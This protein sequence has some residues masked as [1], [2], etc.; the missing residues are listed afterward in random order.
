[1]QTVF[2]QITSHSIAE[3]I[4][5]VRTNTDKCQDNPRLVLKQIAKLLE[6]EFLGTYGLQALLGQEAASQGTSSSNHAEE[7]T[8][9]G[10]LVLLGTTHQS[11]Q[12]RE[13]Q[14][15]NKAHRIGTYHTETRE[16]VLLVVVIGHHTQQ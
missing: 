7:G 5:K 2:Q 4:K 11:L 10:I 13:R 9:H 6:L 3:T 14:Q 15:S 1:M 16:L 8:Q 12:V